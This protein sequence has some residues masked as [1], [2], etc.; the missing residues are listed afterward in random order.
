MITTGWCFHGGQTEQLHQMVLNHIAQ[1]AYLVVKLNPST[2]TNVFSHGNLYMVNISPVPQWF[3]KRVC[4]TQCEYILNGFLAQ[5]MI[6]PE[7]TIFRETLTHLIIDL[8]CR[9]IIV[10]HRLLQH[11]TDFIIDQLIL[12]ETI[13]N[14]AKKFR[15]CSKIE[16]PYTVIKALQC[17]L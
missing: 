8:K 10:A 13:G 6:D 12:A 1:S 3:K 15:C 2:D 14:G 16:D 7:Y 9:G 5:V 11:D 17:N 4:K